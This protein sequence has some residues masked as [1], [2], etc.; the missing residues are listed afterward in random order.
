M[1]VIHTRRIDGRMQR[2]RD[3]AID[4]HRR[5]EYAVQIAERNRTLRHFVDQKAE[6]MPLQIEQN[7]D[8]AAGRDAALD[9][10]LVHGVVLEPGALPVD[11]HGEAFVVF[12]CRFACFFFVD[13]D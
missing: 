10:A 3:T 12:A 2:Q 8:R 7:A 6:R 11:V 5:I 4:A 9:A 1:M 13:R